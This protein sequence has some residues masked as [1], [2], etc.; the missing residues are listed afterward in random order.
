[1]QDP[2]APRRIVFP[3][4]LPSGSVEDLP[5]WLTSGNTAYL[6]QDLSADGVGDLVRALLALAALPVPSQRTL[7]LTQS[8]RQALGLA[9]GLARRRRIGSDAVDATMALIGALSY[10]HSTSLP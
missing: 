1:M 10:A 5:A 9:A 6:I 7:A 8:T 3:V 4:V 2:A